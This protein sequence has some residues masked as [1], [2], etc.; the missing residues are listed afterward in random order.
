MSCGSRFGGRR[1]EAKLSERRRNQTELE[2]R[3]LIAIAAHHVVHSAARPVTVLSESPTVAPTLTVL[4]ELTLAPAVLPGSA[5]AMAVLAA[6]VRS[7][8]TSL[9]PTATIGGMLVIV[10]PQ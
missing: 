9:T 5:T 1:G 7:V 4:S 6:T 8:A 2:L 10:G 3:V